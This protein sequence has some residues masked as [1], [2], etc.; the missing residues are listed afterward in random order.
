MNLSECECPRVEPEDE[1][2]A[3]TRQYIY[4]HP[5]AKSDLLADRI[6]ATAGPV[7]ALTVGSTG[8]SRQI[9]KKLSHGSGG[10]TSNLDPPRRSLHC[11]NT[12]YNR[13]SM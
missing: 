4:W 9:R 11:P 2:G 5:G 8:V 13:P 6:T 3:R 1:V 7:L 12:V 10:V